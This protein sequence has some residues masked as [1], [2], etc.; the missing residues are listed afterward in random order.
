[1]HL[2]RRPIVMNS[3]PVLRRP[4]TRISS[5]TVALSLIVVT[6]DRAAAHVE[7]PLAD[8]WW[9]VWNADWWLWLVIGA[10]GW[11]YARG[12]HRLWRQ[13]APSAGVSRLQV[14]AFAL[15]WLTVVLA[16][17]SPL[18]AL[19]GALFS[20]HMV[21][22]ELLMIVA[23]PLLV[24]GHPLGPMIWALPPAWRKPAAELCRRTGLQSAVRWLSRPLCAWVVGGLMLWVWHI[25]AWFNAAL[26]NHGV[27]A[28]QH[29]CFF[30]SALLFW[31][32]LLQPRRASR[33][34][35]GVL[36]VF[37]TAVHSSILGALLTFSGKPWYSAYATSAQAWGL[38]PLADQELGGLIMWI[39]GGLIY[40]G[41]TLL[42]MASWLRLSDREQ[43][44][45][46]PSLH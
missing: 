36:Y 33:H 6:V 4:P 7:L 5:A 45:R 42:L 11:L 2:R 37:T 18:D 43:P 28:L 14:W 1:M 29:L 40:L 20:A 3:A 10:S 12:V 34:G 25:P 39:P 26:R 22:H 9:S 23:A 27:H 35:L 8:P 13:S 21:Q 46:F 32:A 38:T 41:V 31:W 17:L 30:V 16:L 24:L 44:V 19:G 15:G